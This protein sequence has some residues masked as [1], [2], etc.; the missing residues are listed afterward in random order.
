M[1]Q[2]T[3][4]AQFLQIYDLYV[5]DI[6]RFCVF[7][8]SSRELAE[9]LTQEVFTRYWQSIRAGTAIV[10]DRAFLYTLAR[11]LI[12]DWYRKK[13]DLSLEVLTDAG[14]EFQS[15]DHQSIT[16]SAEVNEILRVVNILD[17]HSREVMLLRFVE[18]FSPSD[19]AKIRGETANT[20]SVRINR[21]IKKV[22]EHIHV[23]GDG[24]KEIY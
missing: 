2:D 12:I 17:E 24:K 20:V 18:G 16:M 6:F 3:S 8:V 22:Q 7:K 5:Q 21:A 15:K 14:F 10:N 23:Q 13:K 9:D 4:Q 11:N 1:D 19:I